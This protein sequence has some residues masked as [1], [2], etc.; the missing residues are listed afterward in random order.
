MTK[1]DRDKYI[2]EKHGHYM[3]KVL[4][5]GDDAALTAAVSKRAVIWNVSSKTL[6]RLTLSCKNKHVCETCFMLCSYSTIG[7]TPSIEASEPEV[8]GNSMTR[9]SSSGGLLSPDV[10]LTGI[11][12]A[13]RV[14]MQ[15]QGK[16]T[17]LLL[18]FSSCALKHTL[19]YPYAVLC[20]RIYCYFFLF[21]TI[22][23]S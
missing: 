8:A 20:F 4:R 9:R 19:C 3:L 2:R 6:A 22:I 17:F 14:L 1:R 7:T 18:V 5:L 13:S 12:H 16:L 23:I 10:E 15:R 11:M 21:E